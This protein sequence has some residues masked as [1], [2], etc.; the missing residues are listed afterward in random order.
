MVDETIKVIREIEDKADE[1]VE[2][3]TVSGSEIVGKAKR[4]AEKLV[5]QARVDAGA[6]AKDDMDDA[7]SIEKVARLK[8]DEMIEKEIDA[9]H[10]K[11]DERKDRAV[12]AVIHNLID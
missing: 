4:D 11:A 6:E 10:K 12:S 9:L 5:E 2:K 1:I 8:T 7:K 3:S